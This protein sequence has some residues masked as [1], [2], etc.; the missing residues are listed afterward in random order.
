MDSV[1]KWVDKNPSFTKKIFDLKILDQL[2]DSGQLINNMKEGVWVEYSIDSSEYNTPASVEI[3][4]KSYAFEIGVTFHKEKGLYKN[5]LRNG[6]WTMFYSYD[7]QLTLDWKRNSITEYENGMKNGEEIIYQNA[8]EQNQKPFIVRNFKNGVADGIQKLYYDRK[9][10]NLKWSQIDSNGGFFS[11][12][13]YYENGKLNNLWLDTFFDHKKAFFLKHYDING[14]LAQTGL[15]V[16][17]SI[18]EGDWKEYYSNGNIKSI[19]F[20]KNNLMDGSCKY[21]YSNRQL[22]TERIFSE[23]KLMEVLSNFDKNGKRRSSGTLK[24]GTGTLI[25]YFEEGNQT[26]TL[27]LKDGF[28][29]SKH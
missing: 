25:H 2:K 14:K 9:P 21:Y 3:L 10:Y 22:N 23:D 1:Q 27:E 5:N 13:A 19:E 6:K 7:N 18:K 16:S 17:D 4:D 28:V 26:D 8:E 12:K 24:N 11:G 29:I 15:L 20:F